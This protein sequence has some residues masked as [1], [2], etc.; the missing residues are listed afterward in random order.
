MNKRPPVYRTCIVSK[1]TLL[2]KDLFRLVKVND[3]I[4]FDKEQTL[5]GRGVYIKKELSV[6]LTAQKRK[7]LNKAF[8][9]DVSDDIYILLIQE[10]S[11]KER[12]R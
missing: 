1:E 8:K 4:S 6:I 2:K 9:K 12:E 5:S 11:K 3:E 7:A 10:L